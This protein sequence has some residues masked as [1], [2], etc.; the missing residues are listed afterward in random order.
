MGACYGKLRGSPYSLVILIPLIRPADFRSL[1]RK[2]DTLYE[3]SQKM[4]LHVCHETYMFSEYIL[5][6]RYTML[7]LLS[8]M[9][10]LHMFLTYFGVSGFGNIGCY[11]NYNCYC[12]FPA[13]L[14]YYVDT[15]IYIYMY[16]KNYP[17]FIIID[18]LILLKMKNLFNRVKNCQ[19]ITRKIHR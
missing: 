14:Y 11:A 12:I 15:C 1:P 16:F 19:Y 6:E 9:F 18:Y 3:C 10:Y 13:L 2:S 8:C 4:A 5:W 17:L 7:Y